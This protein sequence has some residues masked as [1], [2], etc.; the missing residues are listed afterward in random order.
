MFHYHQEAFQVLIHLIIQVNINEK[1]EMGFVFVES[2]FVQAIREG[3]WILLDNINSAPAEVLERLNSLTEDNPM[4]SLYENSDGEV[5]TQSN[6]IHPNFRLFTI[7][8]LNRIYSN[9]LS[10]AFLN[11]VIRICLPPIDQWDASQGNDPTNSDLYELISIQ[12]SNI[13]AGQ[14]LTHLLILMHLNVKQYVKEG[15]LT[16]PSDFLVTYR[17]LEQ[18][19]RTLRY[20]VDQNINPVDACYW[21]LLRSYC[22]SLKDLSEY[23]F[24]LEKLQQT[25][26]D[27]HLCSSSTIYSTPTDRCDQKQ[28][29]WLQQT[30]PIR[31]HFI[32]FEEFL[33]ELILNVIQLLSND[34][35]LIKPTREFLNLFI[36][37]ILLPM[38][39]TDAKLIQ[40]KQTLIDSND[41][42][43]NL[44][45]ILLELIKYKRMKSLRDTQQ[46]ISISNFIQ[47]FLKNELSSFESL[48]HQLN[49]LLD[50]FIS[51]TSFS[52]T[53]ERL[54]FI[55]RT[56]AIVEIFDRFFTSSTFSLFGREI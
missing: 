17:L 36:D 47:T 37:N 11:R 5:L 32:Q 23:Q 50:H 45:N 1:Q 8:N 21:S 19:I 10:S 53:H 6:G 9:K 31:S 52:D 41:N 33:I 54:T 22:S 20:L 18:S 48:C 3:W 25:I 7:A 26:N 15:R 24:Y 2:D 42:Q 49:E 44:S 30:Q 38:T 39:P 12:L 14:Q 27:L 4:L 43:L 56:I 13:P 55:Q 51:E 40:I 16:Y 28:P 34:D 29:L 46:S 35:K